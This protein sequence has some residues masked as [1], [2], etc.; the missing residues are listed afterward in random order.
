[1]RTCDETG[2]G[3]THHARGKCANHYATWLYQQGGRSSDDPFPRLTAEDVQRL[4]DLADAACPRFILILHP[5]FKL[6]EG[7]HL[8]AAAHDKHG[9]HAHGRTA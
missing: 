8:G 4:S 5:N 6:P 3:K 9:R 2:C 7:F 1:M